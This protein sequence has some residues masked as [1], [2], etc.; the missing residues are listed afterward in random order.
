MP[1]RYPLDFRWQLA[2]DAIGFDLP[3]LESEA[4]L[5][6]YSLGNPSATVKGEQ[7]LQL[8]RSMEQQLPPAQLALSLSHLCGS[9]RFNP[10]L[11]AMVS[12]DNLLQACERMASFTHAF[13]PQTMSVETKD[14]LL[15]IHLDSDLPQPLSMILTQWQ[16][17]LTVAHLASRQSINVTS[18]Q[19]KQPDEQAHCWAKQFGAQVIPAQSN[20]LVIG[21]GQASLPFKPLADGVWQFYEQDVLTNIRRLSSSECD[22]ERALSVLLNALPAGKIQSKAVASQ[23]GI[24]CQ[25]LQRRLASKDKTLKKIQVEARRM[26]LN[27]YLKFE[28]VS[29]QELTLLLGFEDESSFGRAC[30]KWYGCTPRQL[31]SQWPLAS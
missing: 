8:W 30:Q 31:R 9:G 1:V 19:L 25:T 13:G 20:T 21:R 14:D 7:Y 27:S 29:L 4:K 2:F 11:R 18:I 28:Y 17:L 3:R 23:M 12:C 22:G 16:L 10:M 15:L 24:G 5:T 26:L 6:K